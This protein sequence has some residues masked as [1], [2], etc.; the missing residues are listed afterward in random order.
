[1]SGGAVQSKG[2]GGSKKSKK[3][4]KCHEE[5][6]STQRPVSLTGKM[7]RPV[8]KKKK[9]SRR[10]E[11]AASGVINGNDEKPQGGRGAPG[12]KFPR[13]SLH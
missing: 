12:V 9:K 8:K 10:P 7:P 2:L 1:M 5:G 6:R 4:K 11:N 3:K 13:T